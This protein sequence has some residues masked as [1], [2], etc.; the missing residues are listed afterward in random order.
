MTSHDYYEAEGLT[1]GLFSYFLG[2]CA[3]NRFKFREIV[4]VLIEKEKA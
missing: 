4:L 3:H 1:T 2:S